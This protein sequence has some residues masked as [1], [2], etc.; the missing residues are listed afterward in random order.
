[1]L[2]STAEIIIWRKARPTLA[3]LPVIPATAIPAVVGTRILL[4]IKNLASEVDDVA[5]T[6]ELT[7]LSQRRPSLAPNVRVPWYLRTGEGASSANEE[8]WGNNTT[9]LESR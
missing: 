3:E 2:Y 9:K 7:A 4:N 6:I 5:P 1:M 8:M